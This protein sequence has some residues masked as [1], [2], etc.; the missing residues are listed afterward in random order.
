MGGRSNIRHF[1]GSVIATEGDRQ[2][3]C[4]QSL[5]SACERKVC[6]QMNKIM[7]DYGKCFQGNTLAVL[8]E[9]DREKSKN[10]SEEITLVLKDEKELVM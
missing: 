8:T 5:R 7:L 4:P 2:G 6:H 9:S 1:T 10:A 3:F